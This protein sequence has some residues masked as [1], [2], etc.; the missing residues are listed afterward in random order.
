MKTTAGHVTTITALLRRTLFPVE[1]PPSQAWSTAFDD[2]DVGTIAVTGRLSAPANARDVILLVHGLGGSSE[3][4]YL[5]SAALAVHAM[6]LASLRLNLR[7]ADG[8]GGDFYHGGL[9]ADL[10][11]A[12]AALTNGGFEHVFVLGY[13]LGGHV[14]LR[15]ATEVEHPE[16]RAVGAVC[17]PLDLAAGADALDRPAM[18]LYRAYVLRRLKENFR[19]AGS[20]GKVPAAVDEI[21]NVTTLRQWDSLTVV[22]RF[23]F[24]DADDYYRR[25]SVGPLLERLRCPAL[26]LATENDPMV[27]PGSIRPFSEIADDRGLTT[28]WLADGGHLGFSRRLDLGQVGPPGPD[29]QI[30]L[31]LLEAGETTAG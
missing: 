9:T 26:L 14:A 6:G 18:A 15:F 25:A 19:K 2:P 28:R 27:P 13:S 29:H 3:S 21:R 17:S 11:A 20:A 7:G 22:P 24:A 8:N 23:G 1:P 4:G 16:V 5:A 12:I 30:P 10:H 31:W